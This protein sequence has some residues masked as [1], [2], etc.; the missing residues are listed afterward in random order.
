MLV[1]INAW[2]NGKKTVLGAAAIILAGLGAFA[3][4]LGDGLQVQDLIT[5]AQ[6]VGAGLAILGI[7]HKIV[8]I[9]D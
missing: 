6:E 2:L 8:K 9:G 4:N 3:T 5:L 7:G 1:K